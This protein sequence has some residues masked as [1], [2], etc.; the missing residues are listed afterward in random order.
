MGIPLTDL[1]FKPRQVSDFYE[2]LLRTFS[3][4]LM[5]IVEYLL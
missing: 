2:P 5:F 3:S 4:H 1:S